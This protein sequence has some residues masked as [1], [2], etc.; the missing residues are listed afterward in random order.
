M[1]FLSH[2]IFPGK[3]LTR[4]CR[5][6]SHWVF[7]GKVFNETYSIPFVVSKGNVVKSRMDPKMVEPTT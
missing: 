1:K 3:V 6:R 2:W 7:T 5:T 4:Q